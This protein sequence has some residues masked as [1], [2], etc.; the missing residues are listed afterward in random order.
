MQQKKSEAWKPTLDYVTVAT[1]RGDSLKCFN[2]AKFCVH[3]VEC[4]HC[5]VSPSTDIFQCLATINIYWRGLEQSHCSKTTGERRD[6]YILH[7]STYSSVCT[8]SSSSPFNYRLWTMRSG[9]IFQFLPLFDFST[10]RMLWPFH[11]KSKKSKYVHAYVSRIVE[12]P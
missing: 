9:W 3:I 2:F 10:P 5:Y 11:A 7:W 4:V 12:C 6:Q 1:G 8:H